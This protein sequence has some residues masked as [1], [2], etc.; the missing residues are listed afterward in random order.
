MVLLPERDEA[1]ELLGSL[2]LARIGVGITE[3]MAVGVLGKEAQDAGPAATAHRHV[4][5]LDHRVLA[6]VGHRVEI[7]I[8]GA[9]RQQ[10]V[11]GDL[12]L[13]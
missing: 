1:E 11:T 3:G 4:M 8:E 12:L 2:T 9:S 5:A 13:S 6:E 10:G 7:E